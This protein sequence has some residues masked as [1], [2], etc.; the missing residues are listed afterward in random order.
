MTDDTE[1][2]D[3]TPTVGFVLFGVVLVGMLTFGVF[4]QALH[5]QLGLLATELVVILGPALLVRRFFDG[6]RPTLGR[7]GLSPR[8]YAWVALTAALIG[9]GA[10]IVTGLIVELAPALQE[11]AREYEEMVKTLLWPDDP[12][13]AAAGIIAVCVAAPLCEEV[14]F[15]GTI[16]PAQLRSGRPWPWI[17]VTNGVLFS[18]L[19]INPFGFLALA[20]VGAFFA[21]LTLL[22]RSLWPA[23]FAHAVLNTVNGVLTPFL[24]KDSVV[25]AVEPQLIELVVGCAVV[26]PLVAAAWAF[27][28]KRLRAVSNV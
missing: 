15:R 21:H 2:R 14:L 19:H 23:I 8:W 27:G 13:L 6:T 26:V 28:A 10:N 5:S 22:T 3:L 12:L 1:T 9:T 18:L 16:L 24:L 7:A 17:I 25:E 11:M 20:V 4:L